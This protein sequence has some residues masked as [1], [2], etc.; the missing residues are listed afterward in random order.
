MIIIIQRT[1]SLYSIYVCSCHVCISIRHARLMD[2]QNVHTSN[3]RSLLV[4]GWFDVCSEVFSG[5]GTG[6]VGDVEGGG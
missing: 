6:G 1:Y 5:E 3:E 2:I 4:V